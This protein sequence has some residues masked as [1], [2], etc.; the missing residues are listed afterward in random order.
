MSGRWKSSCP[1][2]GKLSTDLRIQLLVDDV[3][4]P[5]GKALGRTARKR[6][7]HLNRLVRRARV[8]RCYHLLQKWW[9][10]C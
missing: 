9:M 2:G 3:P 4:K 8:R 6:A 10:T 7:R 5:D 1:G